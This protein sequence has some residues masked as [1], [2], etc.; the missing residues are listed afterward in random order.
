VNL[1]GFRPCVGCSG[2]RGR[3]LTLTGLTT[4]PLRVRLAWPFRLATGDERQI[5]GVEDGAGLSP[6]GRR[7]LTALMTPDGRIGRA[8]FDVA[9]GM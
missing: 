7:F 5:R 4:E 9:Q 8:T 3:L 1:T 6:D 2:F